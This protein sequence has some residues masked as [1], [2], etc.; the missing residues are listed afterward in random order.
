MMEQHDPHHT[1][2]PYCLNR[3][4]RNDDEY[5]EDTT[6][7]CKFCGKEYGLKT[8]ITIDHHTFPLPPA[9]CVNSDAQQETT[10]ADH[11]NPDYCI[12]TPDGNTVKSI[13][14]VTLRDQYK[15]AKHERRA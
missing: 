5:E 12:T 14:A 2:C 11:T 8:T 9:P 3:H 13:N 4:Y 15:R 1:I 10:H 7:I 6:E